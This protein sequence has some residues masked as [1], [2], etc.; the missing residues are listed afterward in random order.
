LPGELRIA[1]F[2]HPIHSGE[3]SRLRDHGF[4]Q[5]LA[6]AGFRLILHGH[7]H[8]AD[9]ALYRYDHAVG[10]RRLDIV[11]AGTFGAPVREWVPGYP[12]QYNV[13]AIRPADI[14]VETRC[15]R[16]VNGAWEP[17]ARWQQGPGK[18]PLPRYVI[19]R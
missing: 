13:L 16:E 8:R 10:G 12:L 19:E 3:D 6:V 4:L 2:H 7:V 17:D 1:A 5:Q 18:D 11:T 15:R 9:S 14:V